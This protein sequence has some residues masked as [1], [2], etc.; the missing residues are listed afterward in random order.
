MA[1]DLVTTSATDAVIFSR[2]GQRIVLSAMLCDASQR[3]IDPRAA[4]QARRRAAHDLDQARERLAV[5]GI[6]A[7]ACDAYPVARLVGCLGIVPAAECTSNPELA[8]QV[9]A[10]EKLAT[11]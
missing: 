11:P 8:V 10:A 4:G 9:H 3:L 2:A 6:E 7:L 5:L 1:A